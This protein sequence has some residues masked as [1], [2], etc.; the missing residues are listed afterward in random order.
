MLVTALAR[1]RRKGMKYSEDGTELLNTGEE[2]L[3]IEPVHASIILKIYADAKIYV[4]DSNGYRTGKMV[5]VSK[6]QQGI[7]FSI[8]GGYEAFWYEI[9]INRE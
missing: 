3:L 2:K 7:K 4:L 9:E 5:P 6:T 8:H 1:Y